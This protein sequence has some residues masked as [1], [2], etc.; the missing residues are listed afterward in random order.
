MWICHACQYILRWEL[1]V[2]CKPHLQYFFSFGSV[3]YLANAHSAL[4]LS[5][6]DL[7]R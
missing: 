5:A 1:M 7:L 4:Q 2:K 3:T 6:T